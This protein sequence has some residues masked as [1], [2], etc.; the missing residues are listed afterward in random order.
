MNRALWL[1]VSRSLANVITFRIKRLRQPKYLAGACIGAAYFYFY[2]YRFLFHA[3]RTPGASPFS[4]LGDLGLDMAALALFGIF[5]VFAWLW[6]GSRAALYFTEAE[7]AWLFP[8]PIDR[9]ALIRFKLLK[10]Q[11]AL[12]FL[13]FVMTLITGRFT[14]GS[15][16]WL[17][18]GGWWIV[19]STLQLHRLGASFALQRLTERGLADW[20]R[21]FAVVGVV[22]ALGAA[23]YFWQRS[24]PGAPQIEPQPRL[25]DWSAWLR[26]FVNAGPGPY[27]LWPF[28]QLLGPWFAS[29]GVAFARALPLP[30]AI[31]AA[32]Y[33][34]VISAHVSFEEASI[35]LSQKR[36]AF[37][38]A[39]R[40]GDLRV[41][42]SPRAAKMPLFRLHP[43][44][45]APVA[46]AW[47]H[48]I[49]EGG[50]RSARFWTGVGA[51]LLICVPA[52]RE[53]AAV[54]IVAA[55]IGGALFVFVFFTNAQLGA[56]IVRREL[57]AVD[58]LK[59]FP[60]RGWQLVLGQLLGPVIGG[61]IRQ[62]F[63]IAL[64][65]LS[66]SVVPEISRA[67]PRIGMFAASIALVI[68]ALNLALMVVPT[69]ATLLFPAW[70]KSGEHTTP[71]LET[72]GLRLIMVVGQL[73]V[74]GVAL[75][76]AVAIGAAAWFG[77]SM[78]GAA[79]FSPIAAG[80]AAALT[81]G[82]E[83]GAG[84]AWLGWLFDRFDASSEA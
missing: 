13:A 51:A 3:A 33:F 66:A 44:G 82:A 80:A 22:A 75:V 56:Q 59:T 4:A 73:L 65:A 39:R 23:F 42:Q 46:F 48:A 53:N 25:A 61:S 41:T 57:S 28:R 84:V 47:K 72:M 27:V 2:F 49:S 43:R 21:R 76:P 10:S 70:F 16:A 83:A 17:R 26:A 60:L 30:V 20:K 8:A 45:F 34:W 6:P 14:Q 12:L 32:H 5:I 38:A 50:L 77:A 64:V 63:A 67:V 7:I 62:W 52:F 24:S 15:Q 81:L 74:V 79:Y 9:P 54:P 11:F 29:D 78:L 1:L 71:G 68:P 18:M 31:M 55:C 69:G 19:L 36:A 58:L 35:V 40:G 37:V